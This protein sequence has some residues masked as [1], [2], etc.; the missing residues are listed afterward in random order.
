MGL[1][2]SGEL[3]ADGLAAFLRDRRTLLVVDS[4][5]HVVDVIAPLLERI[6]REVT[7]VHVLATTRE[8]LR[9]E[10]E[11]V[12]RLPPLDTPQASESLSA[13]GAMGFSAVQLFVER[14]AAR[15][16]SLSLSDDDAPVVA[17]ICRR[18]DGIALAIEFA[19]SRVEA[20]GIR[21]TASLLENRFKM[22]WHGRRTALPRHQ[23]LGGL[24]DWSY[25]LLGELE[26]TL[27]RRLSL[28]VGVFSLDAVAA[29]ANDVDADDAVDALGSLVDKSLVTSVDVG[30]TGVLYR[31]LDTTRAYAQ[32]K[33]EESGERPLIASRHARYLCELLTQESPGSAARESAL[34]RTNSA[35]CERR[36]SGRSRPRVTEGSARAW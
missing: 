8:V 20:H 10:G 23:T 30:G 5:E 27:L 36:S 18:L 14:A 6:T 29:V 2:P 33:L 4:C 12:Y 1:V 26:R 28:F 34:T 9:V 22:L 25:N 11:N 31:L 15:G 32:A 3:V 19:A 13:R 21:G 35:A 7:G 17:D 24:L 16:V